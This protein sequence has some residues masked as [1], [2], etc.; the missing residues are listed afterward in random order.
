MDFNSYFDQY[1]AARDQLGQS[2][3]P[4]VQPSAA[5]GSP[6]MVNTQVLTPS[7]PTPA[8]PLPMEAAAPPPSAIFPTAVQ[9]GVQT[10]IVAAPSA[11]AP[12]AKQQRMAKLM[13][14]FL[15]KKRGF[16]YDEL[17]AKMTELNRAKA[18]SGQAAAEDRKSQNAFVASALQA[19]MKKRPSA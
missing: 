1:S 6:Q 11:Y 13:A 9:A 19:V 17:I 4:P 16:T 12:N 15:G 3:V 2:L 18:A 7:P 5:I 14:G 10:P 8:P